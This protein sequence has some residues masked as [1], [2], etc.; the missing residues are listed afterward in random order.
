MKVKICKEFDFDAAHFL[1]NVAP[2]HKCSRMHGHTYKVQVVCEG[3]PDDRGMVL[4]FAE[5]AE[6]WRPVHDQIDH[7]VLN[8][9]PGLEN[10]TT[11]I[12]TP[13]IMSR[14]PLVSLVS[15]RVYES[16]TTYCEVCK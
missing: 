12:L 14:L 13:W 10:P 9:V 6:A 15:V 16:S 3:E 2:D 11:E 8:D 4:D 1:P 7:R 5:I